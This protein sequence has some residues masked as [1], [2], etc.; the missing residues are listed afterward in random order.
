MW[1]QVNINT[2]LSS[3]FPCLNPSCLRYITEFSLALIWH[4]RQIWDL[5]GVAN[6]RLTICTFYNTFRIVI[7]SW[8]WCHQILECM[9]LNFGWDFRLSLLLCLDNIYTKSSKFLWWA[10]IFSTY[11][12]Q[13]L[14]FFPIASLTAPKITRKHH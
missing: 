5:S 10:S 3:S 4:I 7:L 9:F 12:E 6:R 1:K 14:I 11:E 8:L 13:V 2:E